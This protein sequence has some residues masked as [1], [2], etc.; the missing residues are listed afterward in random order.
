MFPAAAVKRISVWRMSR[1]SIFHTL[2]GGGGSN[3]GG[4]NR[5]G[6]GAQFG[7]PGER[8]PTVVFLQVARC[9]S[10]A[11]RRFSDIASQRE[12]RGVGAV[13]IAPRAGFSLW[14]CGISTL[15]DVA[16][17]IIRFFHNRESL[18]LADIH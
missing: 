3:H 4:L 10:Q 1:R 13:I 7:R 6:G 16:Q 17:R 9:L 8:S 12:S 5:Q 18:G 14:N 15:T 11:L 2:S